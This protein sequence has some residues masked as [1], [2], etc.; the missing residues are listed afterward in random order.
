[1]SDTISDAGHVQAHQ[2][3]P[4]FVF[5]GNQRTWG[6][7]WFDGSFE[8]FHVYV[9]TDEDCT[10]PVFTSA[11]VGSP[12]YAPRENA[13]L[14]LPG[15]DADLLK[16]RDSVLP[17]GSEG[18]VLMIDGRAVT[19]TEAGGNLDESDG[20]GGGSSGSGGSGSGTGSSTARAPIDL[21]DTAWPN[22]GY[23]WTV[24]PVVIEHPAGA[25]TTIQYR[26]VQLPQDVCQ[27]RDTGAIL[28]FGKVSQPVV[29]ASG[30]P[31]VSGLTPKGRITSAV[32]K[33]PTFYGRPIVAWS[34]ALGAD[35]YEVQWSR[36]RY[37]WKAAGTL[38]TY[39]TSASLPLKPGLW[40][41]RIR[42]VD[43]S[44]PGTQQQMSWTE[45]LALRVA[46][47]TFRV[48]GR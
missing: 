13:T 3:T 15:S 44:I 16:A 42:G 48:V 2:L 46:K 35:S 18:T 5:S 14:K 32:S 29:A 26:D 1:V 9:Y 4:G 31:Y 10:N 30:A 23:Y 20:S 19:A 11:I 33:K 27:S 43:S 21:W 25:P 6:L 34:P 24:V 7:P 22:G 40:Y 17:F 47:P 41:Y 37:P 36:S 28:R 38:A 8:L 12:A 45:P 39:S